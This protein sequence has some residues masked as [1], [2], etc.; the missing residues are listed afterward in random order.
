[1]TSVPS[2]AGTVYRIPFSTS[3]HRKF[4]KVYEGE[5][6]ICKFVCVAIHMIVI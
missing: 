2:D 5:T 3:E 6:T 4:G 1:M